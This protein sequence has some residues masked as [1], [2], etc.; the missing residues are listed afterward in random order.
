MQIFGTNQTIFQHL[1][2]RFNMV[3]E[4]LFYSLRWLSSGHYQPFAR[5]S[6]WPPLTVIGHYPTTFSHYFSFYTN[7]KFFHFI[8][9]FLLQ[10]P[11]FRS[12]FRST[13]QFLQTSNQLNISLF[14]N[15]VR[16]KSFGPSEYPRL[17]FF[18]NSGYS[19]LNHQNIQ[20]SFL[21][22]LDLF[23]SSCMVILLGMLK[24]LED[25]F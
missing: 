19:N 3:L 22:L 8:F 13:H 16:V 17:I 12:V 18:L 1:I 23:Y 11:I 24:P 9:S 15:S 4:S 5:P 7:I 10:I 20:D 6:C 21:F 2:L 25:F 14:V